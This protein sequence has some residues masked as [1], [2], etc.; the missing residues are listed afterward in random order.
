MSNAKSILLYT[1]ESSAGA[2]AHYNHALL[3]ALLG[4]GWR[5]VS[6]QPSNDS[7]LLPKQ[8]ALGIEHRFISY[9]PCGE[10]TRSLTDTTDP[11]R[12]LAE[13][14]PDLICFSDTCPL[15]NIAAKHVAIALKIP[16]V[17]ISHSAA[18]YHAQRFPVCLPVVKQQFEFARAVIAPS[19][20]TLDVLRSHFGLAA[21]K[22]HVVL[23]GSSDSALKSAEP[24]L[25]EA[26][27]E[28]SAQH[29]T[30]LQETLE[31]LEHCRHSKPVVSAAAV[32]KEAF[33]LRVNSAT[34]EWP[35]IVLTY[36]RLFLSGA[37]VGLVI[38]NA[39]GQP[40]ALAPASVKATVMAMIRECGKAAFA[41]IVLTET[42]DEL[43][44]TL[45]QYTQVHSLPFSPEAALTPSSAFTVFRAALAGTLE[46]KPATAGSSGKRLLTILDYA[47]QPYSIGDFLFYLMGSMIAAEDAGI[48]KVD[49]FILSDLSR[50]HVDPVMRGWVNA[51]NHHARLMSI[52]PLVE[53]HP[54]FGSLFV[55]DS[56]AELN[57][58]LAKAGRAYQLWPTTELLQKNEYLSY[59]VL[60]AVKDFYERFGRIPKFKFDSQYSDWAGAFF[61]KHA[62][63]CI[64]VTVNLRNNPSFGGHR[65]FVL[66]AWL[67][68]FTRCQESLPVKFFITCAA[69][70]VDPSL[71]KLPNVVFAKN[72][73]TT[74]LQDMALIR[75]SAFHIGCGS[76][77]A[78]MAM[79]NRHPYHIFNNDM[80]PHLP[81]WKGSLVLAENGELLCSF[82]APLQTLGVIPETEEG[83]WE[84]FQLIWSAQDWVAAWSNKEQGA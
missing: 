24:G 29:E 15:S 19:Q 43:A 73:H 59:D 57:A 30:S 76:G 25:G 79:F 62:S 38:A 72:F 3:A 74:L 37:P 18:E 28:Q 56:L 12:I 20:P 77:P 60:I 23:K 81:R 34:P 84:Q 16:F 36:L 80:I 14:K 4:A 58:Y 17:V 44:K 71:R 8:S 45:S 68:F 35:T 78:A 54:R 64:P 32:Q 10:F 7:P 65:N 21:D 61:E 42:P 9:D 6:A 27:S 1:D 39:V 48:E 40:G 82:R 66:A 67:G 49:L 69:S 63:G 26:T 51:K 11:K 2:L 53:F 33:V 46:K 47:I 31:L 83:I 52:L 55:F 41:D 75:F 13:I 50:S 5:A 70:E 22:G